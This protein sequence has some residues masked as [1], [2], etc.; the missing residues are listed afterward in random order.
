MGQERLSVSLVGA[1]TMA[2]GG[3]TW[4]MGNAM[5]RKTTF[6][7]FPA[8]KY[9]M[10]CVYEGVQVPIEAG[11]R[12]E[13]RYFVKLLKRSCIAKHDPLSVLVEPRA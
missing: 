10:R 3:I 13:Q 9:I 1:L 7:N 8:Q 5:L 4:V 6:G 12:I 2:G 11:I